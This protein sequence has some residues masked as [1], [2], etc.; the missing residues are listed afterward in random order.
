MIFEFFIIYIKSLCHLLLTINKSAARGHISRIHDPCA[1][2]ILLPCSHL[3]QGECYRFS[4][5][6]Y[7]AR[8]FVVRV[9]AVIFA[10][11]IDQ[12]LPRLH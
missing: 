5:L 11:F 3:P 6:D 2:I 4:W 1:H 12:T 10:L 9:V 8:P 7:L